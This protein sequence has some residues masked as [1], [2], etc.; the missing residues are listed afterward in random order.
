MTES[1]HDRIAPNCAS[2]VELLQQALDGDVPAAALDA[3]PHASTC[4]A[5]RER[6]ATA[7]LLVAALAVPIRP[8]VPSGLTDSILV[9]VQEDRFA[10]IRRRSYVVAGLIAALAAS[11]LFLIWQ[12]SPPAPVGGNHE[13]EP[14]R[15]QVQPEPPIAPEPRPIRIGDEFARVGQ[16][17][18]ETSKPITEPAV[19]APAVLGLITGSLARP[20][21]PATGFEPA[22]TVLVELPDAAR[23]GLEP[24][25]ETTQKA[26]ARLLRDMG[27]IQVSARPKS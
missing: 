2:T 26:F 16:A 18:I 17:L 10:H 23:T 1:N 19:E 7:R 13:R 3:D 12:Q 5:C 20:V 22:R 4:A 27:G 24:V 6:I 9:A 14:D 15:V 21:S 25:A 8:A 11:V